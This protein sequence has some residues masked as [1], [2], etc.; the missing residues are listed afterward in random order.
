MGVPVEERRGDRHG[1]VVGDRA[2]VVD[3]LESRHGRPRDRYVPIPDVPLLRDR[4]VRNMSGKRRTDYLFTGPRG[5]QI[6]PPN[7]RRDIGWEQLTAEFDLKDFAFHDLR[8]TA[9]V[10][11]IKAGVPITTV[12][13]IAGRS[14]LAVT[15]VYAR[16]AGNDMQDTN[17]TMTDY[18]GAYARRTRGEQEAS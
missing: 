2:L 16:A 7:L 12:R 8:A 4:L 9:I 3:R 15:N 11:A 18:L 10:W 14:S 13:D 6:Y 5:G 17:Q 1:N